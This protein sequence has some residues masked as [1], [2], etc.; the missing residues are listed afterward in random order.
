VS[1]PHAAA[2]LP[3]RNE[4]STIAAVTRAVDAALGD[5]AAVIVHADSSD[6]PDT[7]AAFSTT[8][9]RA[10]KV[11]LTGLPRGKGI[12]VLSALDRLGPH[13]GPVLIAD[14]DTRAPDPALYRALLNLAGRGSSVAIADYP[15]YIDEGNLTHHIARPLIAATTGHDIPQPLAGDLALS[16]GALSALPDAH[17]ALAQPEARGVGGYGIDAFLLLTA[18]R[19]GPVTSLRVET[20]KR[21]AA[22]FP[23]LKDIYDQAVPVLLAMTTACTALPPRPDRDPVYR[24]APRPVDLD[25]LRT[26]VTTLDRFAPY[27]PRYDARPWPLPLAHAWHAVRNGTP[28]AD[29]AR[30]LWP[31]YVH[32]VRTWLTARPGAGELAAAHVR[33][34]AA[35]PFPT[36]SRT[37]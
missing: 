31:Y 18:A 2:V 1:P 10:R 4:P 34:S 25:R 29:A 19:G 8:P 7:V 23:H 3:S 26:M 33:L 20:P 36:R 30:T 6:T 5:P 21:H 35:L 24:A 28:P 14:T 15:R 12:Q 13:V 32:R 16:H 37:P 9:T 11:T 22:S 17:R 27:Q